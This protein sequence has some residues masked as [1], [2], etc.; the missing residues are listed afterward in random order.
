MGLFLQVKSMQ[1][2]LFYLI[3]TTMQVIAT[4]QLLLGQRINQPLIVFT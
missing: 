4:M 3:S 2:G 1:V